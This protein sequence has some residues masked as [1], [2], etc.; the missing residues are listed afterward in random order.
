[1]TIQTEPYFMEKEICKVCKNKDV[2][3]Y[4]THEFWLKWF[5]KLPEFI[6]VKCFKERNND[7]I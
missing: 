6:C 4:Y 7:G 3:N 5:N 1:M 2:Y